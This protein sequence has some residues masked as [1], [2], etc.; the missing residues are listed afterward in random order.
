[1]AI[2]DFR[3][4]RNDRG[5][6]KENYTSVVTYT[7]VYAPVHQKIDPTTDLPTGA[8]LNKKNNDIAELVDIPAILN[9]FV[10]LFVTRKNARPLV[11]RMGLDLR[12]YIGEP[13]NDD[14]KYLMEEDI[15]YEI[16]EYE[17][18][19]EVLHIDIQSNEDD[20]EI[21]LTLKCGFPNLPGQIKDVFV[22][23]KNNGDVFTGIS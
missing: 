2:K 3:F 4:L 22:T 17:P 9:A 13:I 7:D 20:N 6:K 8:T 10:T 16:S 23:L 12:E 1:M 19:V 11:P 5:L 15:R 14:V 21:L 18:R